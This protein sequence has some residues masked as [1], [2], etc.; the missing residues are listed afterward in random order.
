MKNHYTICPRLGR[1]GGRQVAACLCH[2]VGLYCRVTWQ[3]RSLSEGMCV[4]AEGGVA[5]LS[6]RGS[7]KEE[8]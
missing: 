7:Q 5:I 6:W 4:A 8:R 2:S 1:Y 3:L